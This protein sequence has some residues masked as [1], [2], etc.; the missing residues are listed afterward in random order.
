MTAKELQKFI[1]WIDT[2]VPKVTQE[3][4]N[5]ETGS[6]E[7]M[8]FVEFNELM[9]HLGQYVVEE[10]KCTADLDYKAEYNRLSSQVEDLKEQISVLKD[11]ENSMNRKL[12]RYEGA[13]SMVE[14]I[15][16]R[17]FM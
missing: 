13:I 8:C 7:I 9:K 2:D 14:L 10:E 6:Y 1:D 3:L 16:G 12:A 17:N 5:E 15:Y 4:Y 11:T